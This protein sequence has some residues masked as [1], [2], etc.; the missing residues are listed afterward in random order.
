MSSEGAV[1]AAEPRSHR[2]SAWF[3]P[4]TAAVVT[5]LLGLVQVLLSVPL[6]YTD[7]TLPELFILPLVLGI[8][9]VAGGS[10]TMA[11]ERNP[12][13]LL[14]QGCACS[15]VVGLLGALLA[16][17]FYCYSLSTVH[18]EELCAPISFDRYG[19]SSDGC[20]LELLTAYFWSLTLL[21]LLYD[22]GAVVL[23]CL[24][25]VSAL[26]ALKTD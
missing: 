21:L 12:S 16:F 24:L 23:H 13:R 25:S 7:P 8:V 26:K 6:A 20:P 19:H 2:L 5:I 22:T 14:L 17:C 1:P 9:I 3:D 4:E 11:N 18:Q 15:N 10:F